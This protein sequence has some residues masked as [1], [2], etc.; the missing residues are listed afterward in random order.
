[1]RSRSR[2]VVLAALIG[3]LA[4]ALITRF[5]GRAPNGSGARH[6]VWSTSSMLSGF[7]PMLWASLAVWVV[8][9]L[10]WEIAA[11][12]AAPVE[13]RESGAS[14]A[15]H[16]TLVS[17]GQL[18][19]FFGIPGLRAR[20]VPASMV[21]AAAALA[22][23]LLFLVL[24]VWS[25]RILGRNWSGAIAATEGQQLV[26]AGPY[27]SLRHPIYTALL[28]MYACSAIISGE[29]HALVG[30]VLLVAA[31]WRKVRLEEHHLASHFGP[32]YREYRDATW[33]A[34]PGLF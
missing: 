10:Y 33:G 7:T 32:S 31:Y 25:R 16:V 12:S 2:T 26:R 9:S 27:R 6:A 24:A 13:R 17:V 14:R 19:V 8:F 30:L 1:M 29:I 28:G 15:V 22:I 5:A 4:G 18:L 23:Q 3:A 11:T 21:L 34:V 20:F